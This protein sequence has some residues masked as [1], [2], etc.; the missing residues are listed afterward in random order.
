MD[1]P[2]SEL[3]PTDATH[4]VSGRA[5]NLSRD[6]WE[7]GVKKFLL[8]SPEVNQGFLR[9]EIRRLNEENTWLI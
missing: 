5:G 2:E 3:A 8:I 9:A 6:D 7:R 1:K 4:R